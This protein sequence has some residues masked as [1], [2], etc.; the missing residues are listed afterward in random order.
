MQSSM[1]E[2]GL[3]GGVGACKTPGHCTFAK[4]AAEDAAARAAFAVHGARRLGALHERLRAVG[5]PHSRFRARIGTGG[6][7]RKPAKPRPTGRIDPKILSR[8]L[9]ITPVRFQG[10]VR[11]VLNLAVV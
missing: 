3:L 2:R 4:Q 10:P 9:I 7:G 5:P 1:D 6:A 11:A 8:D